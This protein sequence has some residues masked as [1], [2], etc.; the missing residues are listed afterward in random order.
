MGAIKL[1][2]CMQCNS[3]KVALWPLWQQVFSRYVKG[4]VEI[5]FLLM[6]EFPRAHYLL[7]I[8]VLITR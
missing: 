8:S 1:T 2:P 3:L 6:V 7:L 5:V 4:N